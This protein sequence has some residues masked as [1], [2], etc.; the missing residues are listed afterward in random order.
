MIPTFTD[1][2]IRNILTK[3]FLCKTQANFIQRSIQLKDGLITAHIS[4]VNLEFYLI[5]FS[6]TSN[7]N[8]EIGRVIYKISENEKEEFGVLIERIKTIINYNYNN[9]KNNSF[10]KITNHSL[11]IELLEE[12]NS[13]KEWLTWNI[14]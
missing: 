11:F 6:L 7:G 9:V 10:T 12:N 3:H 1:E 2:I 13:F 4:L 8:I 14:L 5:F